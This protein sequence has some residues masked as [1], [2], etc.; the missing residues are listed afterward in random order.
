MLMEDALWVHRPWHEY[1]GTE[2]RFG[3][4]PNGWP[5]HHDEPKTSWVRNWPD[6]HKAFSYEGLERFLKYLS[7]AYL[8]L[9][10]GDPVRA[11]AGRLANLMGRRLGSGEYLL[12]VASGPITRP[13]V[14]FSRMEGAPPYRAGDGGESAS[15]MERDGVLITWPT[16]EENRKGVFVSLRTVD[17]LGREGR[18]KAFELLGIE[19]AT[20]DKLELPGAELTAYPY[21][22]MFL[23]WISD[24]FQSMMED[25]RDPAAPP[26]AFAADPRWSSFEALAQARQQHGLTEDAAILYLLVQRLAEPTPERV[27]RYLGWSSQQHAQAASELVA[28]GLL[29]TAGH[30]GTPRTL[31][32]PEPVASFERYPAPVEVSKLE[33]YWLVEGQRPIL[34]VPLPV[35][36]IHK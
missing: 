24:G 17:L 28:K 12:P 27:Q 18:A 4:V 2:L 20:K 16:K 36:P 21:L 15:G 7:W 11:S 10:A 19:D 13:E 32:L 29:M 22:R 9:P 25:L 3:S 5:G 1:T 35:K 34:N 31:F 8:E 33:T 14:F 26:G 6:P 23:L 30:S